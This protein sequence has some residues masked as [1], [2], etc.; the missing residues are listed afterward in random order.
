MVPNFWLA[1][2]RAAVTMNLKQL[3]YF[4]QIAESGSLSEAARV[5]R[6]AQPSLSL[7]IKNLEDE[8]ETTLLMRHARGVTLT[9]LG[10]MLYEQARLILR[11]A[12]N[13][14]EIIKSHSHNPL[15]NVSVGLPTSACR[16]L[17]LRLMKAVAL[18]HPRISVNIVEAM[19]GGLAEWVQSGRLDVALLYNH[20]AFD[21]VAWTEMMAEDLMLIVPADSEFCELSQISFND[22]VDFELVLPG[23]TNVLRN[24]LES[25]AARAGVHL[26]VII[27]CDSLQAI[28]QLV[29]SGHYTV[30]PHFGLSEEIGR[31][32]FI[33][34]KI[35]DP[36][37]SWRLSVVVS[38]RTVNYRASDAVSIVLANEIKS[39]VDS[40]TWRA[41]LKKKRQSIR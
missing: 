6:I 19:S 39:M 22:L 33:A 23:H 5:L 38:Q 15:G 10:S 28:R 14:K 13:A 37:P 34:I 20:R 29:Q 3:M 40:G 24:V 36:V 7:Q 1:V 8:L 16:G 26:N 11:E 30:F 18:K 21:H 2:L 4:V 32:E 41:T 27:N 17:S 31:G 12:E 9:D 35:I 25:Y